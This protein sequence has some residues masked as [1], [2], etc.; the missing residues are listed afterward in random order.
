MLTG[1]VKPGEREKVREVMGKLIFQAGSPTWPSSPPVPAIAS[2]GIGLDHRALAGPAIASLQHPS[3]HNAWGPHPP[4][5][6]SASLCPGH[7]PSSQHINPAGSGV[8]LIYQSN[9]GLKYLTERSPVIQRPN[10]S[11]SASSDMSH[12]RPQNWCLLFRS[13]LPTPTHLPSRN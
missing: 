5:Q 2:F 10:P 6:G 4:H 7:Q 11:G 3:P 13:P 1:G 12:S 9:D 8:S